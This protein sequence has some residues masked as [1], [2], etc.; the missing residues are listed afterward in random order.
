MSFVRPEFELSN[1]LFKHDIHCN[2]DEISRFYGAKCFGLQYLLM[3]L[4]GNILG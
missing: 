3:R 2:W 1:V 4:G